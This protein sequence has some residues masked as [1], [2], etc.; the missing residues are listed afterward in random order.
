M[1]LDDKLKKQIDDYFERV[2]VD[3]LYFILTSRYGMEDISSTETN[4]IN[5]MKHSD[6]APGKMTGEWFKHVRRKWRRILNKKRRSF[7]KYHMNKEGI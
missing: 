1:K 6:I 2:S 3:D 7:L 4:N 5:N